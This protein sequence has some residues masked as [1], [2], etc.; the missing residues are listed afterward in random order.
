MVHMDTTN[1]TAIVWIDNRC[2]D[3]C[4]TV[5]LGCGLFFL[6]FSTVR[7]YYTDLLGLPVMG[8]SAWTGAGAWPLCCSSS[9]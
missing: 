7:Y 5:L 9:L 6:M 3:L 4:L 2:D 8:M 1:T